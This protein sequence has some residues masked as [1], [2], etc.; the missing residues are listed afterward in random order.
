MTQNG[1]QLS[2]Q[3]IGAA[4]DETVD[5]FTFPFND[6]RKFLLQQLPEILRKK[7]TA[8]M[9]AYFTEYERTAV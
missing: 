4:I 8:V 3:A 1:K 6:S 7:E 5:V 9:S 2:W